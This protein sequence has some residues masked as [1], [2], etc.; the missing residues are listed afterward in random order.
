MLDQWNDPNFCRRY[1]QWRLASPPG[2]EEPDGYDEDDLDDWDEYYNESDR[3]YQA[4]KEGD[5]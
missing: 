4:W 2:W 3:R 1:D 5:R